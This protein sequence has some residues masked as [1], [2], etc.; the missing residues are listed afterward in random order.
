MS[1][2]TFSR[3]ELWPLL[4]LVLP[5]WLL[6]WWLVRQRA[7]ARRHYGAALEE[8]LPLPWGRATRL[9]LAVLLL[10]LT[11]ME[12]R[13]GEEQVQVERRGLDIVFCLDTSRSM[14]ARD[15]APTRLDRAKRDIRSVLPELT[16][17]DRV[18]LVAFAG[19]ARV[20]VPLTHDLD[21]FR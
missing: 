21:S 4:L 5:A 16:R 7:E 9:C 15:M 17:G 10:L 1:E 3:P 20:V 13:L 8:L 2:L 12:P 6:V 19:R 14:L 18:G 11:F